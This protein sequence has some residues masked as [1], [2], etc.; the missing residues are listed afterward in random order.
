MNRTEFAIPVPVL[1]GPGEPIIE[2]ENVEGALEFLRNWPAARQGPIYHTTLRC[3]RAAACGT[4]TA[5]EAR[6]CFVSFSRATG[7][8]A[9]DSTNKLIAARHETVRPRKT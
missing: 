1:G 7:I 5:T 2:I 6:L 9:T 3:C 8:L 4:M